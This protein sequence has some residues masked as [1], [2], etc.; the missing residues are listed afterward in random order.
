MSKLKARINWGGAYRIVE[1]DR[2]NPSFLQLRNTAQ[3]K[4][5]NVQIRIFNSNSKFLV[6][7]K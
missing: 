5:I 4:N 6:E 3:K 2:R 7:L 1:I